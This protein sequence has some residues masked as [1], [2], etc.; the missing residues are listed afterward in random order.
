VSRLSLGLSHACA[1]KTN[2][3]LLCWGDDAFG[4]IGDGSDNTDK[5]V[6]TP[7]RW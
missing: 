3:Q 4:Q 6:P 1:L 2:G 5:A 7:V